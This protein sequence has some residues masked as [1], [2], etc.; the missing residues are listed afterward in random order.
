MTDIGQESGQPLGIPGHLGPFFSLVDVVHDFQHP[1]R[2]LCRII[3][4]EASIISAYFADIMDTILRIDGIDN[5]GIILY[6]LIIIV[7]V[8]PEKKP[9]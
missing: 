9:K 5:E 1:W 8:R 6:L 3:S 7:T 4:A 2:A